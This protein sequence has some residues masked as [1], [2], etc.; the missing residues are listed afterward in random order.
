MGVGYVLLAAYVIGSLAY[1]IIVLTGKTHL[2]VWMA[3]INPLILSGVA[4]SSYRWAPSAIAGYLFPIFVYV[5]VTPLQ[6]L[7]LVYMWNAV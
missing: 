4:Y 7:T 1:S 2:P 3:I 5:G 6:I